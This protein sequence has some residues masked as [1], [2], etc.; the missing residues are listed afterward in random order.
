VSGTSG[1]PSPWQREPGGSRGRRP[2]RSL[3][4]I[5]AA[6]IALAD[7]GGLDAVAMRAVAGR[8]GTAAGSLY[9]YV[10]SR[11]E[12]LDLMADTAVGELDL[13]VAGTSWLDDFVVLA[14]RLSELYRRH[15]W[16]VE[17]ARRPSGFGP[18]T[19]DHFEACLRILAP[20]R[21]PAA[22]KFEAIAMVTGVATLFAQAE[23]GS[24]ADAGRILALARPDA[25]PHLLAALGAP[26]SGGA[27]PDLLDRTVRGLLRGL[28][29]EG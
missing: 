26:A 15:P 4:E 16:L 8:L 18:S 14:R 29:D 24:A 22:A 2:S 27:R 11:D 5:A 20:V 3:G 17:L 21:A 10:R 19:M 25:H 1:A 9:R 23:G 6:A 28:L 13:E 12:L 7:A